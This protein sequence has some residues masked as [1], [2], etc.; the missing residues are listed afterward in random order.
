LI[1]LR[2][3]LSGKTTSVPSG[4]RVLLRYRGYSLLTL[5]DFMDAP[6]AIEMGD[7]LTDISTREQFDSELQLRVSSPHDFIEFNSLHARFPE[8]RKRTSRF[9]A[10][11]LA[12]VPNQED[13][14]VPMKADDKLV[15]LLCRS[16]R[17]LVQH[18]QSA[19]ACIGS[20]VS[21]E[22][23]LQCACLDSGFA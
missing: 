13:A 21:G 12:C 19:L 20:H 10:F 7:C 6:L 23:H 14:V 15:H 3:R 22:M 8:L 18:E 1:S 4:A 17:G 2:E 16:E 11:V 5:P 9:D